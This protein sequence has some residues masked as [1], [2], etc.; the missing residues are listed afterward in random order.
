MGHAVTPTAKRGMATI[1]ARPAIAGLGPHAAALLGMTEPTPLHELAL[2]IADSTARSD[3][4]SFAQM[5]PAEAN[6]E[7]WYDTAQVLHAI[8]PEDRDFIDLALAYL[9][10]RGDAAGYRTIRNAAS[11]NLIRF[12]A[13]P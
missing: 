6:G 11:S 4:E 8:H 12:E 9:D 10:L 3:I 5:M 13:K 7:Q 2:Q 1:T